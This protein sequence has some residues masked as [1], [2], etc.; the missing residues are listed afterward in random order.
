MQMVT[1]LNRIYDIL[2]EE[3]AIRDQEDSKELALQGAFTFDH[4]SFG[5]ESFEPV[6]E[7]ISFSVKPGEMIGL[8][9]ASGTGKSTLINLIMREYEAVH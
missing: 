7:D 1:S 9:G 4:V 3:P 2:D 6:L 5:Y 8:V